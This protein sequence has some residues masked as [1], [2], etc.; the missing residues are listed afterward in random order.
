MLVIKE[1]I[2]LILSLFNGQV[3]NTTR[4]ITVII[5]LNLGLGGSLN[6]DV[7]ATF[8]GLRRV[9][10]ELRRFTTFAA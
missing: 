1:N 9:D 10:V 5:I 8:T 4:T 3:L 7:D 2:D 6:G